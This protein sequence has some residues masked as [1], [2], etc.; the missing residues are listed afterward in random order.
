M[1]SFSGHE[2]GILH[3]VVKYYQEN[4]TIVGSKEYFD[5]GELIKKLSPYSKSNGIEPGFRADT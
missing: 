1:I 3:S 4:E 5:C 2:C